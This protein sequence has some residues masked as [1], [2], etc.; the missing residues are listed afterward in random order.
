MRRDLLA[1]LL[2]Q[3]WGES[4]QTALAAIPIALFLVFS[5][6][7]PLA[8]LQNSASYVD[9]PLPLL[10]MLF[11]PALLGSLVFRAD[12][13]SD[14]RQFLVVHAARPRY[15]W[16]ARQMFWGTALFAITLAVTAAIWIEIAMQSD[17]FLHNIQ[18]RGY[19]GG[20]PGGFYLSQPLNKPWNSAA[21]FDRL[22]LFAAQFTFTSWTAIFTAYALGQFCSLLLKR[23]VLAG[24]LALLLSIL[25]AA[26]ALLTGAWQLSSQWFVLPLGLGA[27]LATWLRMPDWIVARN[28]PKTW[29]LPLASLVLPLLFVTATLPAARLAQLPDQPGQQ[30]FLE[31]V[32]KFEASRPAGE[33]TA[34][35]YFRLHAL[36]V[37]AKTDAERQTLIAQ[38]IE[39]TKRPECRF[40]ETAVLAGWPPYDQISQLSETLL[41]DA[42]RLQ[43]DG[44]LDAALERYLAIVRLRSH[45]LRGQSSISVARE[46]NSST[47]FVLQW[48]L[49]PHQTSDLLRKAVTELQSYPAARIVDLILADRE[50]IRAVLLGKDPPSFLNEKTPRW[51]GYLA[52]LANR[53][54]WERQRALLALDIRTSQLLEHVRAGHG[55]NKYGY[56][57]AAARLQLISQWHMNRAI[58][59][60]QSTY[61]RNWQAYRRATQS[62]FQAATSFLM[63]L[64]LNSRIDVHY[65]L[66]RTLDARTKRL[67]LITQLALLAYRLDHQRYPES[68]RELVPDYLNSLQFDPSSDGPLEYRPQGFDLP[69][70][71]YAGN[72]TIRKSEFSSATI[73]AHTPLLWSVGLGN[74]EPSDGTIRL[75][76]NDENELPESD[77]EEN[78][79]VEVTR[80]EPTPLGVGS[81]IIFTLPKIAPPKAS[82]A[83]NQPK[84]NDANQVKE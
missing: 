16:L 15:V 52:F 60:D 36:L 83:N 63:T 55:G 35:A 54:P 41:A 44:N 82:P 67:G 25:L 43:Q 33:A 9:L 80:L 14:H 66:H 18:V 45:W 5:L 58:M 38:L 84:E 6:A 59:P 32:R 11:L 22:L 56:T 42:Q 71:R 3:T 47:P 48:A 10:T 17:G 28:R 19:G 8:L 26:W 73:P 39:L 61:G 68:L 74:C 30:Q 37:E 20:F 31:Q 12:Q 64:E 40:P 50:Q 21:I 1:R 46:L 53:L 4:W 23:E 79:V 27:M 51:S 13:R 57:D 2:W 62:A 78:E 69:L 49:H 72:N 7:L 65:F 76:L 81:P 77:D 29:A 34:A 70:V 24:L 75:T